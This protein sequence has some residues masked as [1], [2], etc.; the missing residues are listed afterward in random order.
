MSWEHLGGTG[1]VWVCIRAVL[2][3][4]A[5]VALYLPLDEV[6]RG[7]GESISSRRARSRDENHHRQDG[8]ERLAIRTWS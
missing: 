8:L 1:E 2:R 4:D 3:N 6:I 7:L 5:E